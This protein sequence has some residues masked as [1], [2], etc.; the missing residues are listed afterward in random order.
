VVKVQRKTVLDLALEERC[1]LE[2]R[3]AIAVFRR[4]RFN[5]GTHGVSNIVLCERSHAAARIEVE[6]AL[7]GPT[8]ARPCCRLGLPLRRA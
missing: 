3:L 7:H 1:R 4:V 8:D 2:A 5:A 6:E